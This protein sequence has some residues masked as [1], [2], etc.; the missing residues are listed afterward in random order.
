VGDAA[1]QPPDGL[2][3]LGLHEPLLARVQL[4]LGAA[5]LGDVVGDAAE[6][7]PLVGTDGE[8]VVLQ[9]ADRERALGRHGGLEP[10]VEEIGLAGG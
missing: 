3:L 10:S 8:D 5:L 6:P 4:L 7:E 1:G 2:H 9:V